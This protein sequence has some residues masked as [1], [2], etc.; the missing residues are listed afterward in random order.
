LRFC[1]LCDPLATI[2]RGLY[3]HKTDLELRIVSVW[4]RKWQNSAAVVGGPMIRFEGVSLRYGR[5]DSPEVLRDL[6]FT[7]PKG[8]FRWLLGPSGAGKTSL[9]RLLHLSIRPSSGRLLM[10]GADVT[11]GNRRVLQRLRRRI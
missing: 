8:G 10:L 4:A 3:R 5:G 6:S 11:I 1:P 2:L 9:L 7:V